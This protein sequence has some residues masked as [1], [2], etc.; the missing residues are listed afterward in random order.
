MYMVKRNFLLGN[1]FKEVIGTGKE[2]RGPK[3]FFYGD[4]CAPMTFRFVKIVTFM[5]PRNI[6]KFA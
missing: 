4:H 2:E 5:L 6:G 1:P 3:V